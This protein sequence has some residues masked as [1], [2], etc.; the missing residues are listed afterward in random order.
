MLTGELGGQRGETEFHEA[1]VRGAVTTAS[2]EEPREE[3]WIMETEE[4]GG[5]AREPEVRPLR[6]G[7]CGAG[8]GSG[9][10][11]WTSA[12]PVLENTRGSASATGTKCPW[13]LGAEQKA[14]RK[15]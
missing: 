3:V 2:V 8:A 10:G 4:F 14:N 6:T 9:E 5:K 7:L 11:H 12:P 13:P 1:A 15:E